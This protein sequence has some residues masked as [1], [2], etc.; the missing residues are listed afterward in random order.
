MSVCT[1][2]HLLC[3]TVMLL[4]EKQDTHRHEG[5]PRRIEEVE[6]RHHRMKSRHTHLKVKHLMT[7]WVSDMFLDTNKD[8]THTHLYLYL[9][10]IFYVCLIDYM[11]THMH[12]YLFIGFMY[13]Q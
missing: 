2:A 8:C 7:T 11:H 13:V 6:S 5:I 4:P 3:I 9:F 10:Y 1:N 12:L